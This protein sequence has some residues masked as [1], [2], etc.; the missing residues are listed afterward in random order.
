[1][2]LF[3]HITPSSVTGVS[4]AELLMGRRL[5]SCLDR[6]HP[7]YSQ[8]SSDPLPERGVRT[9]RPDDPVY[10]RNYSA[11]PVWIP[12]R[13][14]KETGPVSY[15]ATTES[16]E[17][18]RRHVDQMMKRSPSEPPPDQVQES[19][20]SVVEEPASGVVQPSLE[21]DCEV[22]PLQPSSTPSES[23][24][25]RRVLRPRENL[26]RPDFYRPS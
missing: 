8:S 4:P 24:V 17:V 20:T 14:E 7:D 25:S 26:R 5:R 13:V 15:R 1:M 19:E 21:T 18:L 16:G 2:L 12:A 10:I 11:G 6:V 3:Q 22:P 23:P 9:F